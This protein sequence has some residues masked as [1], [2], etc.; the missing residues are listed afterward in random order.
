MFL[1]G[2]A[3]QLL[4]M[5]PLRGRE[6][7]SMSLPASYAVTIILDVSLT[8]LTSAGWAMV[9]WVW[10][11]LRTPSR[12]PWAIAGLTVQHWIVALEERLKEVS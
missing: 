1:I 9:F 6:R 3:I 5:R 11:K 2:V 12:V 4:F 8:A 7:V 10:F